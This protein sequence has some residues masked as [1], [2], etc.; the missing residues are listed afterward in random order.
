MA[1]NIFLDSLSLKCIHFSHPWKMVSPC[2]RNNHLAFVK[3]VLAV[4]LADSEKTSGALHLFYCPALDIKTL[5][6][7][8]H[9]CEF[10]ILLKSIFIIYIFLKI[11]SV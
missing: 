11:K 2:L 10:I 9:I 8:D 4:G 7:R 6:R 5:Q 1:Q 3:F